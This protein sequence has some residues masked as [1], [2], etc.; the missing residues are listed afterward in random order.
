MV[1]HP[2]VP[3]SPAHGKKKMLFFFFSENRKF[4]VDALKGRCVV[5]GEEIQTLNFNIYSIN[6]VII[7][8][9]TKVISITE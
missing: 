9:Y 6:D 5:L 1:I 7:Q 8:M 4:L 3:L 2:A